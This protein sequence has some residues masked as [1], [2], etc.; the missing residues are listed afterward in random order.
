MTVALTGDGGD[1]LF[2]GYRRYP[3]HVREERAKS[4]LPPAARGILFGT[5]ARLWPK[6]DWA[7]RPLRAKATFEALAADSAA[8]YLR[9][10]TPF[11][12]GDRERVLAPGFGRR[13]AGYDPATVIAGHMADAGTD[14]PLARAQYVDLMTWLPGR[15]LVK[16]DRASM[17]HG[18]EVRPPLLDHE[19]VEWAAGLP[20]AAKLRGSAGKRVLRRALGPLLPAEV[21][22]RRKRGFSI[23]LARWLR[24]GLDGRL[25]AVDAAG[26]LADAGIVAPA[27]FRAVLDEHR[28]GARDHGQLLWALLMLDMFLA[29][30]EGGARRPLAA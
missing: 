11:P 21:L 3:F 28:R 8:G 24:G 29:R 9:A 1:E 23:P 19:L 17:A 26:R 27:G 4:R 16:V 20:A 7:P 18:L 22:G 30:A 13:L 12:P 15:M 14:D 25:E 6:L 10:V 2:A 5:A